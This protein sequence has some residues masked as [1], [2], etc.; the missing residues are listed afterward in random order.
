MHIG[1]MLLTKV[2]LYIALGFAAS[3]LGWSWIDKIAVGFVDF[4]L[5]A[6]IPAYIF[7]S[8]WTNPVSFQDA[9]STAAVASAVILGGSLL[10][11]AWVR[12]EKLS[13]RS[14]ALPEIFMNSAYLAIPLNTVLW[15]SDGAT[16]TIIF[17]TVNTIFTFTLG[18]WMVSSQKR[19]SEIFE[20]PVIYAVVFALALNVFRVEAPSV[21]RQASGIVSL[22]A[23]PAMLFFTGFRLGYIKK[24]IAF[25]AVK[26]S[27]LRIF[28]GFI[29]ALL[30]AYL[31]RLK[32]APLYVC[33]ITA[34]MPSAVNNYIFAE[35]YR[36][37]TEF[38]AASVFVGT[39]FWIIILPA[40]AYF[41]M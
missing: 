38:A 18:I 9:L 15:G 19:A 36:A 39:L 32:G 27:A 5:F 24:N 41:V 8:V 17:N 35:R 31:L 2:F 26:G 14:Y 21:A 6:L 7:L 11:L 29:I 23:L 33:L 10:A 3:R 13:F 1:I 12:R 22:I 40:I 30:A 25:L 34:A 20:I 28:G 16:Y 37:D 4:A